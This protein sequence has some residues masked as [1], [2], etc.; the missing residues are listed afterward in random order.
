MDK[1]SKEEFFSAIRASAILVPYLEQNPDLAA[2]LESPD[3]PD[4]HYY[5]NYALAKD[6][7]PSLKRRVDHM[8]SKNIDPNLQATK[9]L[10]AFM[11]GHRDSQIC[12]VTFNCPTKHYGV[13]CGLVDDRI[14]VICVITG[15]HIPDAYLGESAT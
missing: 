11:E 15:G 13:R 12:N 14:H 1:I 8:V 3:H 4:I 7:L 6:L 9:Q 5:E 2:L 10:V